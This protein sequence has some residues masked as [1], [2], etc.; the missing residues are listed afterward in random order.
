MMTTETKEVAATTQSAFSVRRFSGVIGAEISGVKLSATLSKDIVD[1][2][3]QQLLT[4][5]VVFFRGQHHLDDAGQENFAKL[6]GD[7]VPH[8]T[9]P[10]LSGKS[11]L[12][13]DAST[14]GGRADSWHTDVTFVPDY[15]KLCI[16]RGVVVPEFG[17]DTVW[18]N[19]ARHMKSCQIISNVWWMTCGQY[20]IMN[21]TMRPI[22]QL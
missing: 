22:G 8:P 19:T 3:Y 14:G 20:M 2:V 7:L 18:A 6:F 4:H 17:G 13:L 15:P 12:E 10:A 16:L 11:I 9:Q 21:M 5:K 1:D